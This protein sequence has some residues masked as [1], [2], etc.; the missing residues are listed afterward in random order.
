MVQGEL[1]VVSPPLLPSLQ[2]LDFLPLLALNLVCT[3][4]ALEPLLP[5]CIH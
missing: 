1:A 4:R 3:L 2:G 5:V